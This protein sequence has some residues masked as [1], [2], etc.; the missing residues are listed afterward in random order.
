VP[1]FG[2][3]FTF[4]V[5][6]SAAPEALVA[7]VKRT[8]AELDPR[9]SYEL[10]TL[11]DQLARTLVR[12]RLL[13]TLS[14]FFGALA[15]LLAMIGLYGTLAYTV[16]RRRGEIGLR[17]ALGAASSRVLRMIVSEAGRLVAIG[18]VVGAALTLVGTRWLASFLY[19][20]TPTDP[21]TLTAAAALL[22][23]TALGAALLPALR[24][25]R[26]QP[27]QILRE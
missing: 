13:A 16:T 9:I 11:S 17:M 1:G 19:G 18:I 21:R 15:L 27:S 26:V 25:T 24:A 2:S 14:G 22:A 10:T 6:S 7:A 12:P 5:R 20:V 3:A 23:V 8:L 4:E